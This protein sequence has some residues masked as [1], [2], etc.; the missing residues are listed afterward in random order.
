MSARRARTRGR[1][2]RWGPNPPPPSPSPPPSPPV[3]SPPPSPPAGDNDLDMRHV[4]NQFTCTMA[5]TLREGAIQKGN[6]YHWW[7]A[8]KR[9]YENPVAINWEEFQLV[10]SEQFYPPSYRHAKKS[11]F[12]YLKQGSMSVMEYEHKFNELSR[13]APELVATEEDRCGRF[14]EGLWWEIQAVVTANTYPNMRGLAQAAE[15]VS[16]KLSG[17]V[18]R[19]RRDTP[20]I[21]GPSQGPPKREGS[22][23]SS[24]RGG[25]SGGQGPLQFSG[26]SGAGP[27]IACIVHLSCRLYD[28]FFA[29]SDFSAPQIR[30]RCSPYPHRSFD[31]PRARSSAST[32]V[33][34]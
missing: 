17:S 12:L 30:H 26:N 20:G 3:P 14:E 34:H 1:S 2:Q 31:L 11:E 16:R 25:W 15:R 28:L 33:A 6:A 5:T 7:Q 23:S 9:G 21:G 8:V 4:L 19:R 22:S 13:F 32:L 10:F 27:V 24:T 18:G 29:F